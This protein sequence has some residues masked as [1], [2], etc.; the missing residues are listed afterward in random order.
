VKDQV[1]WQT[2]DQEHQGRGYKVPNGAI[3]TT[4]GDLSKFMLFELGAG[5]A[6]LLKPES[7]EQNYQRVMTAD[8]EMRGGYGIGF[9]TERHDSLVLVGHS[10]GVAGYQARAF[11]NRP[12]KT[13]VIILQNSIGGGFHSGE[14]MVNLFHMITPAKK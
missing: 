12:S 4:V 9:Q 11:I 7:L 2:A 10:G 1:D 13:G 3:Y 8:D 14:L 6:S 5:P